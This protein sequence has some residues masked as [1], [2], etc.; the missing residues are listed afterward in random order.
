MFLPI[1]DPSTGAVMFSV[2]ET[3]AKDIRA[4]AGA[5]RDCQALTPSC[6][7][8][9]SHP[10]SRAIGASATNRWLSHAAG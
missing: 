6:H 1:T 10:D 7:F 9:M 3:S 8:G 2:I 5:R 4:Q